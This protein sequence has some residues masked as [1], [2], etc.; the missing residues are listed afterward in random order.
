MEVIKHYPEIDELVSSITRIANNLDQMTEIMT[1]TSVK[2][3]PEIEKEIK[4]T[5]H[6]TFVA[7][8]LPDYD[9]EILRSVIQD[10]KLENDR[11]KKRDD[12]MRQTIRSIACEP[13]CQYCLLR[14]SECS[15]SDMQLL[16]GKTLKE[17]EEL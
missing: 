17:L 14:G 2:L 9:P 1:T 6:G 5:L 7:C 16:A 4:N 15:G 12:K 11:L 10:L 8:P 3:T 13:D